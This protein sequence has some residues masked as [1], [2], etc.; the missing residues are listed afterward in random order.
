MSRWRPPS[1]KSTAYITAEGHARMKAEFDQLWRVRRPDV[2]KH[3]AAA[4]AEGDRSENAEYQYRKKELREIDSRLKYLTT[5]LQV[6]QIVEVKPRSDGK[7]FFGARVTVSDDEAEERSYRIVGPDEADA[8]AGQI[9]VDAP[10]ARAL[11][12][13]TVGDVVQV[14][15]PSGVQ[16]L[17]IV[18][19]AYQAPA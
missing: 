1:A 11:L 5:R 19:V 12:G 2:V 3:L 4:A 13:R 8:Q 6:L 18:G 14:R 16:T 10:V 17:E 15:L 9:S 7:V